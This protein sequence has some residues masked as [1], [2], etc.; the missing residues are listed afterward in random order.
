MSEFSISFLN[1]STPS[2]MMQIDRDRLLVARFAEPG[3]RIAA[4]GRRAEAAQGVSTQRMFHFDH[5]GA[6]LA[7]DARAVGTGDHRRDVDHADS[8]QRKRRFGLG[9]HAS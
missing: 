5:V 7:Q 4:L 1:S 8:V 3:Q 2:A 6:E 9:L